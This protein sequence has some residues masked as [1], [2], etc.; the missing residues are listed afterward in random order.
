MVHWSRP[1]LQVKY[2][3]YLKRKIWKTLSGKGNS[4]IRWGGWKGGED[5][6]WNWIS[7]CL[8][9]CQQFLIFL[10]FKGDKNLPHRASIYSVVTHYMPI[11]GVSLTS[12]SVDSAW[13]LSVY[14]WQEFCGWKKVEGGVGEKKG[15]ASKDQRKAW[16]SRSEEWGSFFWQNNHITNSFRTEQGKYQ[17]YQPSH[18]QVGGAEHGGDI[19]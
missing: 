12:Y 3:L 1:Q 8:L 17:K 13:D 11:D 19:K 5:W 4:W 2:N 10:K 16:R 14:L 7:F 15:K 18:S 6:S 9:L